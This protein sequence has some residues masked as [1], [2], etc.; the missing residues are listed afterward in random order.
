MKYSLLD[1]CIAETLVGMGS[2]SS[3][4]VE[5]RVTHLITRCQSCVWAV[6]MDLLFVMEDHPDDHLQMKHWE[7]QSQINLLID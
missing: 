3:F 7:S 6:E 5:T 2:L 4:H 1:D